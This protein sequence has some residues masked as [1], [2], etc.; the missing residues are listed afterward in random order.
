MNHNKYKELVESIQPFQEK[1]KKSKD[2]VRICYICERQFKTSH[3]Y[4]SH[5]KQC[6]LKYEMKNN[7]PSPMTNVQ[8]INIVQSLQ[9]RV[10]DLEKLVKK[11]H[12]KKISIL[13]W[14]NNNVSCSTS[15]QQWFQQLEQIITLKHMETIF[16][17]GYIKGLSILIDDIIHIDTEEEHIPL[18]AFHEKHNTI[19]VY[20]QQ[21]Q[22]EGCRWTQMTKQQLRILNMRLQTIF[23]KLL[24]EWKKQKEDYLKQP[25]E[26][27]NEEHK[28]YLNY[29]KKALGDD[30]DDAVI[31][32]TLFKAL[33]TRVKMRLL[34][35]VEYEFTFV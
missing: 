30:K 35:T 20:V 14:L 21:T 24:L 25:I 1:I 32:S 34:G 13:E 18:R 28:I 27:I 10:Q 15:L 31:L 5:L 23:M 11:T 2:K 9:Q 19:Y 7:N 22:E 8:L 4:I 17:F 26:T 6:E 16:K 33:Y 29:R 3:T 12:R